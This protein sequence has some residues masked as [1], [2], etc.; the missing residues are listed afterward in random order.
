MEKMLVYFVPI[1]NILWPF[2]IF[3]G[4]S[5]I[6]WSFGKYIPTISPV[7]VHCVMK[8]LATLYLI[9]AAF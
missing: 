1:W 3:Y 8:N 6:L 9:T 5:V 4:H 7:L 2:G